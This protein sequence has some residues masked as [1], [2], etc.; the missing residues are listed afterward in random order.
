LLFSFAHDFLSFRSL[1][2][3]GSRLGL[4][5]PA[6]PIARFLGLG[7]EQWYSRSIRRVVASAI[8]LAE[9]S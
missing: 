5:V 3:H 2:C 6:N 4:S 8:T 1:S 9:T 7:F